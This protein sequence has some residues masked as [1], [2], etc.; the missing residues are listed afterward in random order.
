VATEADR[1]AAPATASRVHLDV[2]ICTTTGVPLALDAAP[3]VR[4][5]DGSVASIN[6]PMTRLRPVDEHEPAHFGANLAMIDYGAVVATIAVDGEQASVL[7]QPGSPG[8]V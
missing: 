7:L 2:E 4:L 6:V 3:S 1:S 5:S 8:S